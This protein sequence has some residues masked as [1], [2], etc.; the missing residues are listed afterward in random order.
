MNALANLKSFFAGD[1]KPNGPQQNRGT[2]RHRW[3]SYF[4]TLTPAQQS[5][6]LAYEGNDTVGRPE[7]FAAPSPRE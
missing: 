5:A 2:P 6:V 1:H 4:D 3:V 7:D